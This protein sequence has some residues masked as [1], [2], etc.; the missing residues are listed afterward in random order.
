VASGE[1]AFFVEAGDAGLVAG[2]ASAVDGGLLTHSESFEI[3]PMLAQR[4]RREHIPCRVHRGSIATPPQ[5]LSSHWRRQYCAPRGRRCQ[6]R[7]C[8]GSNTKL[9]CRV[10]NRFSRGDGKVESEIKEV[11]YKG[12]CTDADTVTGADDGVEATAVVGGRVEVDEVV[13][14]DVEADTEVDVNMVVAAD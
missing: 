2:A 13:A 7:S 11:S 9:L 10:R 1:A 12:L 4:R 6:Q 8:S 5:S 14:V 3:L